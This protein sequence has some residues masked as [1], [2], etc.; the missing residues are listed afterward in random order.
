MKHWL[1]AGVLALALA[2]TLFLGRPHRPAAEAAV[3]TGSYTNFTY[4]P[5]A[6]AGTWFIS[7]TSTDTFPNQVQVTFPATTGLNSFNP[8]GACPAGSVAS[9]VTCTLAAGATM[10][11]GF[12]TPLPQQ[13][14]AYVATIG[15]VT[16]QWGINGPTGPITIVPGS[17]Q[18]LIGGVLTNN[19]VPANPALCPVPTAVPTLTPTPTATPIT[20]TLLG[21]PSP[22]IPVFQN[23]AAGGLFNPI[24]KTP[25]PR[26]VVAVAPQTGIDP[27]GC[28]PPPGA[29]VAGICLRPPNTGDAGLKALEG[30]AGD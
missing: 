20:F 16:F 5:G 9:P 27:G 3:T 30:E 8:P 26:P 29:G 17:T 18:S 4:S 15:P 10:L 6:Q 2:A 22:V 19:N 23:P 1:P 12:T 13:C 11:L 28:N 25:T 14:A 21:Q 7:I 24:A